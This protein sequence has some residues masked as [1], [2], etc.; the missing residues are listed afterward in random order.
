M[1]QRF[2][3]PGI[4]TSSGFNAAGFPAQSLFVRLITLVDDYGRYEAD[5]RLIT[6]YAFAMRDDVKLPQ[7]VAWLT[8]LSKAD[9]I[10]LYES[11]GKRYL[12]ISRWQERARCASK[13]P[14]P[15]EEDGRGEKH[16]QIYF[17]QGDVTKRIKIGYTS[18]AVNMRLANLQTGCT[19]K[20]VLLLCIPGTLEEEK[21]LHEKFASHRLDG[22][23]FECGKV[24]VDFIAD[25]KCK[26]LSTSDS[27]CSPPSPSSSPEVIAITSSPLAIPLPVELDNEPFRKAW[28]EYLQYRAERKLPKYTNTG[29]AKLY[30]KLSKWGMDTV[31]W[32]IDKT[33]TSNW[34]GLFH[35][36]ELRGG[37]NSQVDARPSPV[38]PSD[39]PLERSAPDDILG[40]LRA[41]REE[42]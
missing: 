12:Q 31:L 23:W 19:E 10:T 6:G 8:E 3:R 40:G 14:A 11:S 27:R 33:I 22:E 26:H 37:N 1:P 4:T 35:P 25:N 32:S 9:L 2:L 17:I 36:S 20:L 24:V 38:A 7:V 28:E 21:S 29:T 16:G 41:I 5:A 42:E 34:Q 39:I 18:N 30:K 13:Y 15:P